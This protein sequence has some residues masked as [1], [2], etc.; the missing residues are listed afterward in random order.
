MQKLEVTFVKFF[1]LIFYLFSA[2][3]V[4]LITKNLA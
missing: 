2:F 4:V 3:V 1:F